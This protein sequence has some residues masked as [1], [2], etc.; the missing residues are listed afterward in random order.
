MEE[1]KLTWGRDMHGRWIKGRVARGRSR[2]R[3][4]GQEEAED[5]EKDVD[6]FTHKYT[7]NKLTKFEV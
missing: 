5:E 7:F 1:V 2:R 4:G 3:V 6:S